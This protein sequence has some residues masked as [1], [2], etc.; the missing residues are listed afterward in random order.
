MKICATYKETS[1]QQKLSYTHITRTKRA[2]ELLYID[3][4]RSISPISYNRARFIVHDIDDAF[5]VH[6]KECMKEKGETSKVFH[7]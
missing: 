6:F 5:K 3:V 2:G 4:I 7:V 1:Q